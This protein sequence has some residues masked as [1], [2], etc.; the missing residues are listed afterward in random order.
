VLLMLAGAASALWVSR[1]AVNRVILQWEQTPLPPREP[2]RSLPVPIAPI[3]PPSD[4][5]N[6]AKPSSG[7][8]R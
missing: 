8:P 2:V 6:D 4:A 1:D 5:P 3:P 7:A